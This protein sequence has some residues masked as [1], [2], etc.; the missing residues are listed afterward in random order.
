MT[1]SRARVLA[2]DDDPETCEL[3]RQTL[4]NRGFEVHVAH[5]G[6]DALGRLEL[7]DMVVTDLNMSGL[8]GIEL[9]RRVVQAGLDTPVIVLTAFGSLDTAIAAIRAGAY[10]FITK[11]LDVEVLE[12]ALRRALAHRRLREEVRR[13]RVAA[14]EAPAIGSMVGAS[15]PMR[16]LFDQVAR[17][18]DSEATVLVTGES[19][20]GKELVAR[21][22]HD[23]SRRARGPFV[24]L[25]CAALPETLLES[26]LFGHERGAFT[27]ARTAKQGLFLAA[28]GGTLLLDEIGDLPLAVQPKLLRVLEERSVRPLGSASEHP[29]NVRLI[30]ATHRDLEALVDAGSF[31]AD[32]FYR[33]N[34]IELQV[35]PLRVRGNDVLVLAQHFV[36]RFARESHRSVSGIDVAAAHKL[37]AYPWPGNVRELRNCIERA[38][39][40]TRSAEIGVQDLSER[41]RKWSSEASAPGREASEAFETL[42]QVERR[43]IISVFHAAGGNRSL[44]AQILDV[45]R[46]T[47]YRKLVAYGVISARPGAP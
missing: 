8:G 40:L 14:T 33:V 13:L 26:E 35:P 42:E 30:A 2:V 32:L 44:A 20:C 31:R 1:S 46:K 17:L 3:L 19:G 10:D 38:V 7:A 23:H 36:E 5:S 29:V 18:A 39:A 37:L 16:A 34:V 12:I 24:A 11:P 28:D 21:A 41:V 9:C 4:E 43:H 25:N 27:D 22:I 47:L 45:D 6:E 15:D